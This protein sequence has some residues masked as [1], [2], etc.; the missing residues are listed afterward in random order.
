MLKLFTS[1]FALRTENLSHPT[2]SGAPSSDGAC[3]RSE[4]V[5]KRF[6]PSFTWI[7]SQRD[8]IRLG[9]FRPLLI[10]HSAFRIPHS[11]LRSLAFLRGKSEFSNSVGYFIVFSVRKGAKVGAIYANFVAL[12]ESFVYVYAHYVG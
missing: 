3:F 1:H 7:S 2:S 11:E 8:F 6:H 9:G 10:P 4:F 5:A 12:E